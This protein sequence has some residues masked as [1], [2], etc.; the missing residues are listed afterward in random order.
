[1]YSAR[2]RYAHLWSVNSIVSLTSAEGG[3]ARGRTQG[4]KPRAH[5]CPGSG[6]RS[7]AAGGRQGWRCLRAGGLGCLCQARPSRLSVSAVI[8]IAGA[9]C[10]CDSPLCTK[11]A[12]ILD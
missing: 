5:A 2:V 9:L 1:M 7:L 8:I 6:A 4:L 12:A 10:V 3:R 11:T